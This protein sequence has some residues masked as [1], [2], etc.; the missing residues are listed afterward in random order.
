MRIIFFVKQWLSNL[1]LR[2]HQNHLEGLFKHRFPGPSP[3]A[4]NPDSV[5]LG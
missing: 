5:G 3:I 2:G 1:N 4:K